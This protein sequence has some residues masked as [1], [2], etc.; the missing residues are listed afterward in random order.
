VQILIRKRDVEDEVGL[1]LF[2]ERDKLGHVI[3]INLR[4]FDFAVELRG[5]GIA[6]LFCAAGQ[7]DF[8]KYLRVLRTLVDHHAADAP[9]SYDQHLAHFQPSPRYI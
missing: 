6:L 4:G 7:H 1:N 2:D 9:C 3:G 5:D 8:C